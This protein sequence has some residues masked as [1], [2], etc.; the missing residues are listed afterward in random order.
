M[1]DNRS[2]DDKPYVKLSAAIN[3][4]YCKTHNYDFL[5]YQPYL[6]GEES[7]THNCLD[8]N[9]LELRHVAWSKVL[10]TKKALSLNYDYVVYLDSDCIFNDFERTVESLI[11]EHESLNMILFR[12]YVS[13]GYRFL[14]NS[15]FYVLKVCD[16]SRR[17]VDMWYNVNIPQYNSGHTWDQMGLWNII[18]DDPTVFVSGEW[19][20]HP[21]VIT[22]GSIQFLR[23]LTTIEDE[24]RIPFFTEMIDLKNIHV[25]ENINSIEVIRFNTREFI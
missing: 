10:A 8:P 20:F 3:K 4:E 13:D 17:L 5:Y 1:S 25:D 11:Q 6:E 15:G 21:G 22:D 23:H 16:H 24:S 7:A 19:M 9:T 12:D 18:P 14:P 2:F